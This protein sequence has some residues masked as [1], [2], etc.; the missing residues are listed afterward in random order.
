M[1]KKLPNYFLRVRVRITVRCLMYPIG[2]PLA[3]LLTSPDRS[4]DPRSIFVSQLVS[5]ARHLRKIEL[6]KCR[7]TNDRHKLSADGQTMIERCSTD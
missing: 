7:P 4:F 6:P 1:L 2:R 3:D 5:A